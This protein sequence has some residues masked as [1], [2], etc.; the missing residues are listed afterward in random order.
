MTPLAFADGKR[1][2]RAVPRWLGTPGGGGGVGSGHGYLP[3][4]R[5]AE[6]FDR[7]LEHMHQ[8]PLVVC[9]RPRRAG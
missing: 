4:W 7:E 3:R 1:C 2:L 9:P 5:E 6:V 8:Q